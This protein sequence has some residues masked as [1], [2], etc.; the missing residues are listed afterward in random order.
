M[1]KKKLFGL[2]CHT[3]MQGPTISLGD[4]YLTQAAAEAEHAEMDGNED[5]D[6]DF[7][8][9]EII[10]QDD[11][12]IV[13]TF[14]ATITVTDAADK[15][16]VLKAVAELYLSQPLNELQKLI[17]QTY[18][19]GDFSH[20]ETIGQTRGSECGDT[21]V[22]FLMAEAHDADGDPA[23]LAQQLNSA[24]RDLQDLQHELMSPRSTEIQRG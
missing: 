15:N 7:G 8:V 11:G 6:N 13:D 1:S 21:L 3:I 9:A 5:E 12:T 24:I 17:L 22:E 19:N 4:I 16:E 23:Q 18:A 2:I 10:V 20:L 14:G